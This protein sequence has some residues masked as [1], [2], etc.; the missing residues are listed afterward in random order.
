[1]KKYTEIKVTSNG[2]VGKVPKSCKVVNLSSAPREEVARTLSTQAGGSLDYQFI[3]LHGKTCFIHELN[4][5]SY[6]KKHVK[7]L[8]VV[9]D[10]DR[11]A[12]IKIRNII[13]RSKYERVGKMVYC[14]EKSKFRPENL[15]GLKRRYAN[16][17]HSMSTVKLL[18]AKPFCPGHLENIVE[19]TVVSTHDDCAGSIAGLTVTLNRYS[20]PFEIENARIEYQ[21]GWITTKKDINKSTLSCTY[22]G[23]SDVLPENDKYWKYKTGYP[24]YVDTDRGPKA[25]VISQKT[26]II[27]GKTIMDKMATVAIWFKQKIIG[28]IDY[29]KGMFVKNDKGGGNKLAW[30]TLPKVVP[31]TI[32]MFALVRSKMVETNASKAIKEANKMIA[33][34]NVNKMMSKVGPGGDKTFLQKNLSDSFAAYVAMTQSFNASEAVVVANNIA[35]QSNRKNRLIYAMVSSTATAAYY[36]LNGGII[37]SCIVLVLLVIMFFMPKLEPEWLIML[38]IC[39]TSRTLVGLVINVLMALIETMMGPPGSTTV[40][41]MFMYTVAQILAF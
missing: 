12:D 16:H 17:H 38:N 25:M 27:G 24:Q 26:D 21:E 3:D 18:Q 40:I 39:L 36:A 13:R 19:S 10:D 6:H 4:T 30:T 7:V 37:V 15:N 14:L 22:K 28:I 20:V 8:F 34:M 29:I 5:T 31:S 41:R 35:A 23:L 9:D 33:T 1:M 32:N 11:N 2:A